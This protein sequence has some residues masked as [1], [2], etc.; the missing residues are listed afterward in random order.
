MNV[1]SVKVEFSIPRDKDL[2]EKVITEGIV[3]NHPWEEP[4]IIVTTA[5]EVRVRTIKP[6]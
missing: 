2:L 4:V 1:G 3:P 6:K 5:Q